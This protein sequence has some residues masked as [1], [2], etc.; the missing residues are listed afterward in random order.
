MNKLFYILLVFSSFQLHAQI[1]CTNPSVG[2]FIGSAYTGITNHSNDKISTGQ[3]AGLTFEQ[4]VGGDFS[5]LTEVGVLRYQL[6]HYS[7]SNFE[8]LPFD[9]YKFND[10]YDYFELGVSGKYYLYV[11]KISYYVRLG[12]NF[13][14]NFQK[15]RKY[16]GLDQA[17][18][19]VE[20]E[21]ESFTVQKIVNDNKDY[22]SPLAGGLTVG[23]G[24][25]YYI[26]RNLNIY[27]SPFG[28]LQF[29]SPVEGAYAILDNTDKFRFFALGIMAGVHFRKPKY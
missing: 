16:E 11:D 17:G 26:N 23:L 15:T 6:V 28:K 2:I 29:Q 19:I 9:P 12:L 1:K 7:D 25:A 21:Y 8:S 20:S 22:Y 3:Y 18:N 24:A 4:P 5:I 10:R 27:L 14:G 13:Y